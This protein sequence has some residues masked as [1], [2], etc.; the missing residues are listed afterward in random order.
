MSRTYLRF[1][2]G[3][4]IVTV[5]SGTKRGARTI[6][7]SPNTSTFCKVLFSLG[8]SN[9]NL[10]FLA[11]ATQLLRFE[12]VLRLELSPTVLGDVSLRHC[13]AAC[14]VSGGRR[15]GREHVVR[16]LLLTARTMPQRKAGVERKAKL[17]LRLLMEV[18]LRSCTR[19]SL[20]RRLEKVWDDERN[21]GWGMA[22]R[23]EA[24]LFCLLRCQRG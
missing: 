15:S 22:K 9:F 1:C 7:T 13:D 8:L 24:S 3:R 5:G 14:T 18:R 12:G 2:G 21:G 17:L 11:A 10:L 23:N 6:L 19:R 4:L 20:R 16:G